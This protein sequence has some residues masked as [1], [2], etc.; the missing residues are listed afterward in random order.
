[1]PCGSR[2]CRRSPGGIASSA[3]TIQGTAHRRS[4]LD[5][6]GLAREVPTEQWLGRAATVRE[7]GMDAIADD[8]VRRWFT[9]C[10]AGDRKPWRNMLVS[11]PREGYA[12]C[13]EAIAAMDLRPEL[14]AIKVPVIVILGRHDPVVD[15]ENRR[16]LARAGEVVEIDAAHLANVEQPGAFVEALTR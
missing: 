4:G 3:T 7:N 1:M 9:P 11:T 8:V 16:L 13:C 10:F 12:R 5:D 15:E 2:T 6:R 14:T